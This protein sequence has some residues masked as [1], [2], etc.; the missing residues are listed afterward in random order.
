MSCPAPTCWQSL[1]RRR[2]VISRVSK[3]RQEA[4]AETEAA[5]RVVAA[6][7]KAP[8]TSRR[9]QTRNE[10]AQDRPA[11][12][13]EASATERSGKSKISATAVEVSNDRDPETAAKNRT[14]RK[15]FTEDEE[16][17]PETPHPPPTPTSNSFGQVQSNRQDK[18]EDAA[19]ETRE[20]STADHRHG[21]EVKGK[22]K[23][24]DEEVE[25]GKRDLTART[26][27]EADDAT[28][29]KP[30]TRCRTAT[31][32]PPMA[33]QCNSLNGTNSKDRV[34]AAATTIKVEVTTVEAVATK[35]EEVEDRIDSATTQ[36]HLHVP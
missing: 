33:R 22:G 20:V 6:R 21:K 25:A 17:G 35:V 11:R 8:T 18:E 15:S 7:V 5:G 28:M 26:T 23:V 34:K 19:T 31:P 4:E 30:S 32:T 14:D 36:Q 24:K 13:L 2:A 9:S 10:V 27:A 3:A 1:S 12:A 16:D 29:T